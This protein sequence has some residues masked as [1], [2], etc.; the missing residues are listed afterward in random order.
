MRIIGGNLKG[1][2]VIAPKNIKARPTTDF[3][4]EA[5]FNILR[6]E[7]HFE[8]LKVLD[9]FAGIGGV[10]FEFASRGCHVTSIEREEIHIKFIAKTV[11]EFG[12]ENFIIKR[13]NVFTITPDL[14]QQYDIVGYCV[15]N[16]IIG[17]FFNFC[18]SYTRFNPNGPI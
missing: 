10:S 1:R 9:L 6:N 5:L 12:I 4:K 2:K 13:G 16:R 15:E 3:A 14:N 17:S 18:I 7:F 11:R 8:N